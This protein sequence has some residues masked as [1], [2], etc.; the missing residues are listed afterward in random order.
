MTI[1]D[2]LFLVVMGVILFY[3]GK[4]LWDYFFTDPK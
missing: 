2:Y 3:G 4:A 1:I